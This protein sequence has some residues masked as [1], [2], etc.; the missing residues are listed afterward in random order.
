MRILRLTAL[1]MVLAMAV[2]GCSGSSSSSSSSSD[3][4]IRVTR[5]GPIVPIFH[6]IK[7]T[8]NTYPLMYLIY[9]PLVSIAADEKTIEPRLAESWTVSDDARTFT[10]VLRDDVTWQDGKP[11]TADDVVFTATWAARFP[12]AYQGQP[13]AWNQIAGAAEA[14]DGATELSGAVA[15]D[16]KTVKLTLT[17]PNAGFL[18]Q[19]ANAPNVI[20]PQHL[21]EKETG[22]T[23]E[24]SKFAKKPVGTGPF[25]LTTYKA[26]QYVELAANKDYFAGAPKTDRI[27]WKILSGNQIATQL[28][29]G[30]LDIAFGMP[31]EN[32]S[33]LKNA[34]GVELTDNLSVGMVGLFTRTEAPALKDKRVRRAL[35][36]G[37]DRQALIDKVLGGKAE[38]LWNPPGLSL[39][40]LETYD[41]DQ[42]KARAL[43]ADAKWDEA[44]KLRL[45]YWKDAP[46]AGQALPIIQQQLA[47]IGVKVSLNPLESDD[48]DDMVTNPERRGEW[49][50]DYEFGGTYGLGPD[51]S[52][53]QYG[54]CKGNKVQTGYQNCDLADLFVKGRSIV[55]PDTQA[56]V[57][58]EIA[59]TIN[60][61]ADAVYL[62]QPYLLNGVSDSVSGVV[63][64]PFDRHSF[65]KATEWSKK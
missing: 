25:K 35:Y 45:V 56:K 36:Y 34:K 37:I 11:F 18:A 27:I 57:Y 52:S 29:S 23:L 65:L 13:M 47:E 49:E 39:D 10:F 64:Y 38:R 31:Q 55:D 20:V 43:L 48:W 42:D 54:T 6:P 26:D 30:D 33:T 50:L 14:A 12:G 59:E 15:V 41:F 63:A 1:V 32:R 3:S 5:D 44:T 7:A 60:Q 17:E 21:L 62:W 4:T 2:A 19:M 28:E 16:K 46:M 61:A 24:T 40:G 58:R 22:K 8:D 53:A 51:Y 9:D